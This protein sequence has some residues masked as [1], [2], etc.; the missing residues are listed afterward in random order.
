MWAY[1]KMT[2][3]DEQERTAVMTAQRALWL[4]KAAR[5]I[6]YNRDQIAFALKASSEIKRVVV[7]IGHPVV[8]STVG[9]LW[10]NRL[11][12]DIAALYPRAQ[13]VA[14]IDCGTAVGFALAALADGASVI[15]LQVSSAVLG[16]VYDIA[17]RLGATV[18]NSTHPALNLLF[19]QNPV[20][21]CYAWLQCW[22]VTAALSVKGTESER[23]N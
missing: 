18:D 23:Q 22:P 21:A 2:N 4:A 12:T 17:Q 13:F 1:R 7:L 14:V 3:L 11:I 19:Y 20:S 16:R 8:S 5:V 15:R 9:W 10:F 6:I